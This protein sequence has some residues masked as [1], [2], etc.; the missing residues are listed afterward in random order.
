MYLPALV[1]VFT[2]PQMPIQRYQNK[3]YLA[4]QIKPCIV[5]KRQGKTNSASMKK[6]PSAAI[7]AT[8]QKTEA[9]HGYFC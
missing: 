4:K 5:L 7:A 3:R 8:N 6:T 1:Y 9:K 2:N